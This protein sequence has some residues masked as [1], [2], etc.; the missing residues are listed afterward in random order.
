MCL[1][2]EAL[3]RP[4]TTLRAWSRLLSKVPKGFENF[5]PK[6]DKSDKAASDAEKS[7]SQAKES[8][9][10]EE[11]NDAKLKS[12]GGGSGS[13]G[14]DGNGEGPKRKKKK[15]KDDDFTVYEINLPTL[16]FLGLGAFVMLLSVLSPREK[17]GQEVTFQ[18]FKRD[19]LEAGKVSKVEITNNTRC[20][21]YLEGSDRVAVW[22]SVGSVDSLERQLDDAQYDL[23]L[24]PRQFVTVQFVTETNW[25]SEMLKL[26]PHLVI[27]GLWIFAMTKMSG[28]GI[29]GM[30]GMGGKGG[31]KNPFSVGKSNATLIKADEGTKV[32]F[33]D[34]AGLDEAKVEVVEFVQFL[35]DPSVFTKLGAKIPKGALLVGPP[36]TGKTMLAKAVA[37]EASVPF[38]SISG[39]DFIEMFVGLPCPF[40]RFA[41][42]THTRNRSVHAHSSVSL[43]LHRRG[44][45]PRARFVRKGAGRRAV[46]HLH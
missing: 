21:V 11:V 45:C 44:P 7:E 8:R 39:S 23:G 12:D 1:I 10:E 46:Y 4:P 20:N 40:A 9:G 2:V 34:V 18:E 19:Y 22:F 6:G 43:V 36:G 14:G 35:R 3:S 5:Y 17:G 24:H 15:K 33:K 27:L 26:T 38:Y 29:G 13:G 30:G 42:P 31:G 32:A 37:G 41:R 16:A 25:A 28:G